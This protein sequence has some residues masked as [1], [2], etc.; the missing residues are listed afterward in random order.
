LL[1]ANAALP[2]CGGGR[3]GVGMAREVAEQVPEEVLRAFG[4]SGAR[5]QS[6]EAGKVNRHWRLEAESQTVVVRRYGVPRGSRRL[7]GSRN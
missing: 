1:R 7:R 3:D 6:F 5:Q 2:S 4:L